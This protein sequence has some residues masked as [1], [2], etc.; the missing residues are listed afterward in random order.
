M[1]TIYIGIDPGK[2]GA[3]AVLVE[4]ENGKTFLTALFD[5]DSVP[6]IDLA[7]WIIAW[8]RQPGT[9]AAIEQVHS[10]PGQGVASTF[11]FGQNYGEWLGMLAA[12]RLEP[13]LVRPQEW[14]KAMGLKPEKDKQK[15]KAASRVLAGRLFPGRRPMFKRVRDTDRA[16]AA[17]IAAYARWHA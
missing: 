5:R 8:G 7:E 9:V 6:L 3:V 16:E 14:R 4:N 11:K 13:V 17:L 2:R 1:G 10:M 15:R 12:A